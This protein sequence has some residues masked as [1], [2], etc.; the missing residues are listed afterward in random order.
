MNTPTLFSLLCACALMV[1]ACEHE[2][3]EP[4]ACTV[5]K[6]SA[7]VY[8]NAIPIDQIQEPGCE[9]AV[10]PNELDNYVRLNDSDYIRDL[11][12]NPNNPN[13][14]V[15]VQSVVKPSE[16]WE[17]LWW[18]DQKTHEKKRLDSSYW[19]GYGDLSWGGE[20]L[21]YALGYNTCLLQINT[22][23]KD[24][25]AN[26]KHPSLS[27]NGVY[28]VYWDKSAFLY[29]TNKNI[30]RSSTNI[31]V[32]PAMWSS[33]SKYF[34]S[35]K[36]FFP[37]VIESTTI[38]DFAKREIFESATSFGSTFNCYSHSGDQ[39]LAAGGHFAI[40]TVE[41]KKWRVHPHCIN[42]QF[43]KIIPLTLTK[44]YM[45]IKRYVEVNDPYITLISRYF[46]VFDEN[47]ENERRV[48]MNFDF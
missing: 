20:F 19:N 34:L 29:N 5:P 44:E 26:T 17:I 31:D 25:F 47:W 38:T 33:N 12:V 45:V 23:K 28:F 11:V 40:D 7:A 39:I 1:H 16:N 42:K 4:Q 27:P 14:W 2:P 18:V 48:E 22:G 15:Y 41:Q 35:I 21:A 10:E 13:Q 8:K 3:M 37:F 43:T 30:V 36:S 9:F 24:V 6:P 46:H 32:N